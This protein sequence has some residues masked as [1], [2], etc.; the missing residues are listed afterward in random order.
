MGRDLFYHGDV[1]R[2]DPHTFL[3]FNLAVTVGQDETLSSGHNFKYYIKGSG[4]EQNSLVTNPHSFTEGTLSGE[5][6]CAR[7]E[8][9]QKSLG[10]PMGFGP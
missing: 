6:S 10:V 1:G 2:K 8:S 9:P 7:G 5:T 4:Q 3:E